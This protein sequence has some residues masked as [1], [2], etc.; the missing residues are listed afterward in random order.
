MWYVKRKR[1]NIQIHTN[2]TAN[3]EVWAGEKSC[4]SRE[5]SLSSQSEFNPWD[6][7]GGRTKSIKAVL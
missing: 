1:Q 7:H 3:P 5:R 2:L 6:P 4:L